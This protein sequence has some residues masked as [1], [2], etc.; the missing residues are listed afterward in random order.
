MH[1]SS[2]VEGKP[3]YKV[4]FYREGNSYLDG[5]LGEFINY[6]APEHGGFKGNV[7]FSNYAHLCYLFD[8]FS[9]MDLKHNI[10]VPGT[11]GSTCTIEVKYKGQLKS[12]RYDIPIATPE[13]YALQQV[14]EK[15]KLETKWKKIKDND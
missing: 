10:L 14:I 11:C 4:V 12:I 3:D 2:A 9:F 15:L 6:K 1:I 7:D 13:L 5:Y 8:H